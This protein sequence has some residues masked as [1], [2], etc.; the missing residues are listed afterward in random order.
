LAAT[1]LADLPQI[2]QAT[3]V[4]TTRYWLWRFDRFTD[5]VELDNFW[6]KTPQQCLLDLRVAANPQAGFP[7]SSSEI[8]LATDCYFPKTTPTVPAELKGRAV[9]R[10]GR[11]QLMLDLHVQ[12]ARDGRLN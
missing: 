9:H 12:L 4:A 5:P 7:S 6:G 8:E 11:N 1:D 2:A 10:F 3:P